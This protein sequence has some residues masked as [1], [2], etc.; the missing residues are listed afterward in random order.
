MRC[1]IW[2]Y[3]YNFKNVKNTNG[4]VLFLVKLETEACNFAKSNT[5]PWVF[6]MFFELYKW[7]QITQ[8]IT[9]NQFKYSD[10]D[11]EDTVISEPL[12]H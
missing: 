3:L 7:Y 5:P 6:F 11:L 12:N 4:G 1:V 2:Y 10:E 8:N 9:Y